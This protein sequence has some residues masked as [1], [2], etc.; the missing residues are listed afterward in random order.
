M[1]PQPRP[2]LQRYVPHLSS[3][4]DDEVALSGAARPASA[5]LDPGSQARVGDGPAEA[6]VTAHGAGDPAE[7]DEQ[8][9]VVRS[10]SMASAPAAT[11]VPQRPSLTRQKSDTLPTVHKEEWT[12]ASWVAGLP[13]VMQAIAQV[14]VDADKGAGAHGQNEDDGHRNSELEFVRR[15]GRERVSPERMHA[16]LVEGRLL[17]RLSEV[18]SSAAVRFS[19]QRAATALEL[20]EKFSQESPTHMAYGGLDSFYR[21]STACWGRRPPTWRRASIESTP[22]LATRSTRSRPQT[23]AP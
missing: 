19:E 15:L 4:D 18:L 6:T 23:T 20:H 10:Q 2:R 16:L 21:G 11:S 5:G 7:H 14:L 17:T 12:V 1:P 9:K 22:S 3:D 13:E 8:H